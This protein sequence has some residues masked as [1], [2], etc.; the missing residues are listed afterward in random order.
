MAITYALEG[1]SSLEDQLGIGHIISARVT[2]SAGTDAVLTSNDRSLT[3]T[4]AAAGDYTITFG[5]VFNATPMVTVT[6]VATFATNT[7]M[8]T[9]ILAPA[10]NS[11]RI[12]TAVLALTGTAT[13]ILNALTDLDFHV[14]IAGKR[15]N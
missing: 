9:S 1:G 10:T 2:G 13:T 12:Q 8:C 7:G 14:M 6:P 15:F 3:M 5:E 11:V 4:R